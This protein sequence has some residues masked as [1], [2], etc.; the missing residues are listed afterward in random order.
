MPSNT[1]EANKRR[2]GCELRVRKES[3]RAAISTQRCGRDGA[4]K[5]APANAWVER[6]HVAKP[7]MGCRFT[8][9]PSH[10]PTDTPPAALRLHKILQPKQRRWLGARWETRP[11]RDPMSRPRGQADRQSFNLAPAGANERRYG[12]D[13]FF[14]LEHIRLRISGCSARTGPDTAS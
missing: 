11:A 6:H 1:R 8:L 9:V 10:A 13:L 2:R 7:P 14:L 12:H 3:G 5:R 4:G